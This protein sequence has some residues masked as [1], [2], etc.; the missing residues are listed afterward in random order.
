MFQT[1]GRSCYA[2]SLDPFNS[3]RHL[4]VSYIGV[5]TLNEHLNLG[6]GGA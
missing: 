5:S 3:M 6:L 2:A 1:L 4:E